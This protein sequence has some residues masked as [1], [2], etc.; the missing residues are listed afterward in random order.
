MFA[1]MEA[2]KI[3]EVLVEPMKEFFT[4]VAYHCSY[5]E[6][7]VST[8]FG[9]LDCPSYFLVNTPEETPQAAAPT[10]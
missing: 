4:H 7:V 10:Q 5:T 3:P 9:L 6:F 1:A 2:V 8:A